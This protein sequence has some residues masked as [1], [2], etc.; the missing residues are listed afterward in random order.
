MLHIVRDSPL[1]ATRIEECLQLALTGDHLLLIQDGVIASSLP[2]YVSRF[3]QS[4]L[5]VSILAEDL[6]ARGLRPL[7]GE[8]IDM[9]GFVRLV[10]EQGSPLRW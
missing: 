1:S 4:G 5:H 3:E 8:I 10:A 9:A 6:L 2:A 7:A